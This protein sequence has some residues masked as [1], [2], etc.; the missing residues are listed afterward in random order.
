MHIVRL[1]SLGV[2]EHA[3]EEAIRP[4]IAEGHTFSVYDR[5]TD[6]DQ[7]VRE[8]SGADAAILA[9]MP[10]PGPVLARTSGLRFLDVAFTG[11]DHVGMQTAKDM[12]I[13]ISNASG[14]S[15][16][17]VA[18]LT[19]QMILSLL[20]NVPALTE[21]CRAGLDKSGLVGSELH[22]KTV[23]IVGLGA[24]GLT[25]ARLCQAFGCRVIGTSRTQT[26]GLRDGIPCCSLDEVLKESDIVVLHCPLTEKTRHLI[27]RDT[28]KRMKP[29]AYLINMARGPVVNE[30]DLLAALEEGTIAGAGV[31]VFSIEPPLPVDYP[32]LRSP[33][34][35]V[36]PHAAFATKESMLLRLQIVMDNLRAFLDGAPRNV[37]ER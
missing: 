19:L 5:T 18:E 33:N 35:L 24:I 28:L 1:E 23:G 37:V 10:L 14:Y 16:W 30:D 25:T 31:D 15:T 4:F 9:N 22:G 7:L 27:C 3:W 32:L 26:E 2:D 34:L 11:V 20:R 12:G 21:R 17:A 36:T 29:T 13:T 8:L 6:E